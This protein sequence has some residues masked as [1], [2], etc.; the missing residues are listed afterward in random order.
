MIT[1]ARSSPK[2]SFTASRTGMK[3]IPNTTE[4]VLNMIFVLSPPCSPSPWG[5]GDTFVFDTA[6]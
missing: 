1:S 4:A 5:R 2:A 3:T 6:S